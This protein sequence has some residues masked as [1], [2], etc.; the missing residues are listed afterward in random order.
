MPPTLYDEEY[1]RHA[2]AGS[3]EWHN[4]ADVAGLYPGI[5]AKA[6]FRA[7]ESLLDI[8]AG[9]GE[10][11]AVAAAQG[12]SRA[13]G[14]DYS[15]A[16]VRLASQTLQAQGVADRAQ[17]RLGDARNLPVDDGS[18]D[19]VTMVDVVEHLSP[20]ELEDVLTEVRRVL[21]PSG[22]LFIHTMPN[23]SIYDVTYRVMRFGARL[24]G[25]S[26]PAEPRN[27]YE[28]SMHVNEQTR[29]SLRRVLRRVGYQR[30]EVRFGDFVYTDFVPSARGRRI[31]R[32]LARHRP[33]AWLARGELFA[34]AWNRAS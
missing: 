12:A 17:V 16:A 10:L 26:W 2:C 25:R 28:Q 29:S 32:E 14:I 5:L 21:G 18:I 34:T 20:A 27:S 13:I 8:G 31:Y 30:V 9:R 23:R 6:G 1:Y 19:L 33:T 7:G 24:A 11:V 4:G 3:D 15:E 22:R